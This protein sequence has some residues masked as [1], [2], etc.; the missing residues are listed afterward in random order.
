MRGLDNVGMVRSDDP[1]VVGDV[2]EKFVDGGKDPW[3]R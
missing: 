1:I 2:G 3:V